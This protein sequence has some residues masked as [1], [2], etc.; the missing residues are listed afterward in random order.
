VRTDQPRELVLAELVREQVL[1]RTR[2]EIPHSVEVEMEEVEQ[3][4]GLTA[5]R[6][7]IWVETKSQKGILIGRQGAMVRDIGVAARRQ[8]EHELGEHVYLDLTVKVR[9]RW[10]RDEALL[11]RLGIE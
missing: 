4:D 9:K 8:L 7:N 1:A 3:R 6:A 5:V 2:E 10:R 11:D